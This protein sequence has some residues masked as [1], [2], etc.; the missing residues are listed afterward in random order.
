M[1]YPVRTKIILFSLI[2]VLSAYAVLFALGLGEMRQQAN[3]DAQRWLSEHADNHAYR[4][5]L[6]LTTLRDSTRQLAAGLSPQQPQALQIAALLD[7]LAVTPLADIAGVQWQAG[8]PWW[9]RRGQAA[10]E[11]LPSSQRLTQLAQARWQTPPD[12]S[13]GVR[14]QFPIRQHQQVR[15]SAFLQIAPQRLYQLLQAGL[16]EDA[17][18]YLLDERGRFS[19]HPNP[20]QTGRAALGATL[21][22][23][24]AHA[25][26]NYLDGSED[27][28]QLRLAHWQG[29]PGEHLAVLRPVS[30]TP[31]HIALIS[32]EASLLQAVQQRSYWAGGLLLVSLLVI[33][34]AIV[35]AASRT[36]R[37]LEALAQATRQ[38]AED[39]SRPALPPAGDDE[40]GRLSRAIRHLLDTQERQQHEA[41]AQYEAL[42]ARMRARTRELGELIDRDRRQREQLQQASDQAEAANRAKSEFLSNMSHELRTPLNGVLGYAQLLRRDSAGD[43]REREYLDAIASCGEHLLTLINDV[44]DLSKIEA[45]HLQAELAPLDLRALLDGVH[46][47]VAQAAQ[48]KGLRLQFELADDLP[49]AIHS[50][51]TKLRQILL[52]LLGNALKF[53]DSGQIGLRVSVDQSLLHF[54]VEDSGRGIAEEQLAHIFDAFAQAEAGVAEG[55]TG[56]GLAIN[57]RLIGVLGGQPMQV[58]STPGVGS[59]FRFSLPLVE[60]DAGQLPQTGEHKPPGAAVQLAQGQQA[61]LMVVDDSADNRRILHELLSDAG[62]A[63]DVFSDA[64]RAL[65]HLRAHSIDL[66]LMDIRMPGMDGLSAARAIR[67]DPALAHNRLVAI[68]ASVFPEFRRQVSDAGFDAFLAKPVR[69]EELF[70]LLGEQLGVRYQHAAETTP[71]PPELNALPAATAAQL[72]QQIEQALEIGDVGQLQQGLAA[73]TQRLPPAL[74]D[75]IAACAR[76]FDFDAL[77]ALAGLLRE[78]V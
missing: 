61:R 77:Q 60:A 47:I 58:S 19:L 78:P 38:I 74:C 68:S 4:V 56:L 24:Q 14:Y 32:S 59:C 39:G 76:R 62:F 71:Q 3:K 72:A 22:A 43:S 67:S 57:Q 15:G 30:G 13:P 36:L 25:W 73:D 18:V 55:G 34:A 8:E 48:A 70:S 9:M 63:V 31:W 42:Q 11:P 17:E 75:H 1:R 41:D 66:V 27:E 50:D 54:A 16:A 51:A 28:L 6:A 5:Q 35:L 69:S 23:P 40:I 12:G 37:P 53:T 49:K 26:Q 45:G 7:R 20:Q 44:L 29:R 33:I 65:A 2:P 52:N 21:D 64:E 10:A 46:D